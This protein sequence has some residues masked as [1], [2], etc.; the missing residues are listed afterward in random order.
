MPFVTRQRTYY[1]DGVEVPE[2]S[3]TDFGR[4]VYYKNI[5]TTKY[6]KEITT[7]VEGD[8]LAYAAYYRKPS[9][10]IV[11]TYVYAKVPLGEDLTMYCSKTNGSFAG[12][13]TGA[14]D[15]VKESNFSPWNTVSESVANLWGNTPYNRQ[16]ANDIYTKG[17]IP[18]TTKVEVTVYDDWDYTTE[19]IVP[20]EVSADDDYDYTE[21]VPST[22]FDNY[23][24]K[25]KLYSLVKNN[26][27]YYKY[28][29][30]LNATVVG[31]PTIVDGV[32]S[33]FV[34]DSAYLRL[35]NVFAP[36][37][38]SW[39]MVFRCR[40]TAAGYLFGQQTTNVHTPQLCVLSTGALMTYISSNTSGWDIA[41]GVSSTSLID[42]N[43]WYYIKT[44]FTG[45]QY[46]ISVSE[47]GL[48]YTPYITINSTLNIYKTSEFIRIGGDKGNNHWSDSIDLTK[49]YIK[50][51]NKDWWHGTKAVEST[52]EDF[53]YYTTKIIA[54]DPY[55]AKYERISQVFSV[56]NLQTYIVPE[57]V[58]KL[59]VACRASRG[60]NSEDGTI[61]GG[62]GGSVVCDL[63][64]TP[65]QTLYI[66]VGNIPSSAG[67]PSYNASDIRIFGTGLENRI[68]VAGGGGSAAWR[69]GTGTGG[70]G[71]GLTGGAGKD[72]DYAHAGKG[73]TQSV[74]GAGG[75]VDLVTS[76]WSSAG[77]AGSL[78]MGGTSDNHVNHYAIGGCGGAGYYGGGGGGG[79][80]TA[81][82]NKAA[83][84]GGGSS[85]TDDTLCDN[86][87]HLQGVNN[88][89]GYVKISYI[90]E[91]K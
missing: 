34:T 90:K 47:N 49:S 29:T 4:T 76:Q 74:G 8:I 39:E 71:G 12:W 62:G 6:W 60:A 63:D 85:Y 51:N 65:N 43:K 33:G 28:G 50:I 9:T 56:G 35:S 64:V 27:T 61:L 32:V 20:V 11:P 82:Y 77:G 52:K 59:N 72:Q 79:M 36:E 16:Y 30:E 13:A 14:D 73:G 58:T 38:K 78:G 31:S 88:G 55:F 53:D 45:T 54:Y 17:M 80:H 37:N 18:T 5:V 48:E 87:V 24:D 1:K 69:R 75:S 19:E 89:E 70:K 21:F 68:I 83:G 42:F 15:I 23:E 22:Q 57:N 84:G 3:I 46:I 44:E 41:N 7:E 86:V 10:A 40:A 67:T 66:T 91:L 25:H 81:H 26:K 2:S